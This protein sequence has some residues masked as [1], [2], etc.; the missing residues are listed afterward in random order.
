M[1]FQLSFISLRVPIPT[2][3]YLE[4]IF[5]PWPA[6]QI[7]GVVQLS[8]LSGFLFSISKYDR[9]LPLFP[10]LFPIIID[11]ITC[12]F[13]LIFAPSCTPGLTVMFIFP[14]IVSTDLVTP[15][16]ASDTFSHSV[17]SMLFSCLRNFGCL[18]TFIFKF[19]SPLGPF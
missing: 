10:F 17:D 4:L 16:T 3:R 9:L 14:H 5:P 8:G 6:L 18:S 15:K 13:N 1:H 19:R 12:P 2:F 11:N 7:F